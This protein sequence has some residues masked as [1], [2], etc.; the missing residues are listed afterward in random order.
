[1]QPA[2]KPGERPADYFMDLQDRLCAFHIGAIHL[3][4]I[5]NPQ[6]I[7]C[8]DVKYHF[9]SGHGLFQGRRVAQIPNHPVSPQL[10]DIPEVAARAD[11]QPQICT[12][13]GQSASH[14]TAHESRRT[15][16]KNQHLAIGTWHLAF[17]KDL[18]NC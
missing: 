11:Q 2:F 6:P 12:V 3:V 15:G 7:I 17:T 10:L 5:A 13:R 8:S 1:M 18:A 9:A 16:E 4:R 14:V